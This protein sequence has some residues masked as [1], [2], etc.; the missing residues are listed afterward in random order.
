MCGSF[1]KGFDGGGLT[2]NWSVHMW[3][4]VVVVDLRLASV[5]GSLGMDL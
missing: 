5:C 4:F 3:V 1:R 2:A